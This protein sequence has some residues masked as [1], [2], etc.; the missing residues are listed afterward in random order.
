VGREAN[1]ED[2]EGGA[3]AERDPGQEYGAPFADQE[4]AEDDPDRQDDAVEEALGEE[5]PGAHE[6]RHVALAQRLDPEQVASARRE[7]V[8]RAAADCDRREE[9]ALVHGVARAGQQVLPAQRHEEDVGPDETEGGGQRPGGE[10]RHRL[11]RLGEV[12]LAQEEDE[13][14][15]GGR[16]ADQESNECAP[17]RGAHAS[18]SMS[19]AMGNGG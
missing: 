15:N 10:R 14:G 4:R 9:L 7:D 16:G 3:R 11:P 8:V 2:A 19:A 1:E 18:I 5:R 17:P 6:H 12:D 13:K